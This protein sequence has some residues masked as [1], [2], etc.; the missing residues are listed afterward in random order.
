MPS[1]KW[2]GFGKL[3]G[4]AGVE[5][6]SD[7]SKILTQYSNDIFGHNNVI[8]PDIINQIWMP[9]LNSNK[10]IMTPDNQ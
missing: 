5:G 6:F 9:Y 2:L 4:Q 7:D 10:G 8:K 1:K 3:F